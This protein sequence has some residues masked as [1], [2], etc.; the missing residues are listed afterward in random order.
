M[1]HSGSVDPVNRSTP[2]VAT[3]VGASGSRVQ[4]PQLFAL[5][6]GTF[7]SRSQQT[8]GQ[9]AD[10]ARPG[11]LERSVGHASAWM[12]GASATNSSSAQIP[13][14]RACLACLTKTSL[15]PAC[16]EMDA[17]RRLRCLP[18]FTSYP[19]PGY[20][21]GSASGLVLDRPTQVRIFQ[22]RDGDG[23]PMADRLQLDVSGARRRSGRRAAAGR[24]RAAA[25]KS[26]VR[27][28]I[29]PSPRRHRGIGRA[30]FG[31]R[32]PVPRHTLASGVPDVYLT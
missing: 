9:G 12:A 16:A 3:R 27:H 25:A 5:I 2:G 14:R 10:A 23:S 1:Q 8:F 7:G 30:H 17:G 22:R 32:C 19:S 24:R 6:V 18:T 29:P 26:A 11:Q 13:V 31:P 21:A 20:G 15:A 28:Q 4:Q